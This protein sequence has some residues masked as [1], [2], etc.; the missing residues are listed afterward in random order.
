MRRIENL[1]LQRKL[2]VKPTI[3]KKSESHCRVYAREAHSFTQNHHSKLNPYPFLD[4]IIT[5]ILR[6]PT[7]LATHLTSFPVAKLSLI[8]FSIAG[9]TGKEQFVGSKCE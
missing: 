8:G 1:K 4:Y 2:E 3:L 6:W 7:P 5:N 9:D